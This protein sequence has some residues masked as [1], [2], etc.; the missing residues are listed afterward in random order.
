MS[1]TDAIFQTQNG[2][3]TGSGRTIHISVQRSSHRCVVKSLCHRGFSAI[4]RPL[5]RSIKRWLGFNYR[6]RCFA[7]RT[8]Q[9]ASPKRIRASARKSPRAFSDANKPGHVIKAVSI[10]AFFDIRYQRIAHTVSFNIIVHAAQDLTEPP[11]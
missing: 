1:R 7:N 9:Q 6:P 4:K 5:D 10:K 3:S 2:P 11:V 8:A